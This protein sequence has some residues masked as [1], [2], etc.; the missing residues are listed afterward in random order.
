MIKE[1]F[2]D[3]D[4]LL[5]CLDPR[6][7]ILAATFFSIA[8]AIS[9]S[10]S[11]LVMAALFCLILF[12]HAK[13]N[14][15]RFIKR[16]IIVNG[17]IIFLWF[18]LP[19]TFPGKIIFG[20]GPLNVS[21]EGIHYALL[22]T[23]KSNLIITA[24]ITLLSTS[25]IFSLVHALSHLHFPEKL[26]Q[27]LFFT[28]RYI[29]V[30]YLEYLNLRKTLKVRCFKAGTNLRT[31]KTFANIVAMLLLKSYDRAERVYKA[32]LCRGFRGRYYVLEHSAMTRK[33]IMVGALMFI[34][35]LGMYICQWIPR[36]L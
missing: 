4:S 1:E 11:I 26:I 21:K 22:I 8:V 31:Y 33:D 12:F 28:Y 34:F 24:C 19:F 29:H 14:F 7:K 18:F 30:L 2:I 36:Y 10:W 32:M 17:F 27:L 5:H 9:T 23:I 16:I 15:K 35:I 25:S 20:I 3:G 6:I 13:L